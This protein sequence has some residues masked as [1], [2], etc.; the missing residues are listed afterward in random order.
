MHRRPSGY[1]PSPCRSVSLVREHFAWEGNHELGGFIERAVECD[2]AAALL[3][4]DAVGNR[5][6]KPMPSP[7]G[8]VAKN[9]RN[10]LSLDVIRNS[11][12]IV[13]HADFDRIADIARRDPRYGIEIGLVAAACALAAGVALAPIRPPALVKASRV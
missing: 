6:A 11:R 7:V 12:E 9:G 8:W 2:H 3:R 13:R 5:Q 1:A 10:N 4:D